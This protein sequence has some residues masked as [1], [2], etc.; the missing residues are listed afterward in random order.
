VNLIIVA[1]FLGAGKTTLLLKIASDLVSLKRMRVAIIENEIGQIGIDNQ[2]LELEGLKVQ[3]LQSGCICCALSSDL[4]TTLDQLQ[5]S[6]HPDVVILEPSGVA[7]AA[8]ILEVIDRSPLGI[9][10]RKVIVLVDATRFRAIMAITFPFVQDSLN[11]A[12]IVVVNK[13]DGVDRR[14]T[15]EI[16]KEVECLT[17]TAKVLKISATQGTGLKELMREVC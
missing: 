10:E 2:Y 4:I 5:K 6:Y 12:D 9:S 13:I 8:K 14:A 15:E 16:T 1:G 7:N 3:Q 17:G 11:V